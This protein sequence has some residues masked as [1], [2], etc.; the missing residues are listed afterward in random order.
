MYSGRNE[1]L[2]SVR[3]APVADVRPWLLVKRLLFI[4]KLASA[5][6]V[7]KQDFWSCHMENGEVKA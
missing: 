4:F 1:S 6:A 2:E 3:E 5:W 7:A